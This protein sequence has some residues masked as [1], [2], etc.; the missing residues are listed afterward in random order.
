MEGIHRIIF[1][2]FPLPGA[3]TTIEL[4]CIKHIDNKTT[5]QLSNHD[6]PPT[7]LLKFFGWPQSRGLKIMPILS[8]MQWLIFNRSTC[9]IDW[10]VVNIWKLILG[11]N[12]FMIALHDCWLSNYFSKVIDHGRGNFKIRLKNALCRNETIKLLIFE[13]YVT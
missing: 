3:C 6:G 2:Y 1:K 11:Y 13:F 8:S 4:P 9:C 10:M 7:V 12:C 5:T